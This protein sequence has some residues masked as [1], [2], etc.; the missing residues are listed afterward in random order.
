MLVGFWA[1]DQVTKTR[2][3]G[4]SDTR[5]ARSS[6]V[7]LPSRAVIVFSKALQRELTQ[8]LI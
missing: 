5:C 4:E 3:A 1:E 2:G 7:S 8:F 6:G